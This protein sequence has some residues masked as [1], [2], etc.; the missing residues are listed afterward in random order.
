MVKVL[1]MPR[2]IQV[3]PG[4]LQSI[5]KVTD[6]HLTKQKYI[7]CSSQYKHN[8]LFPLLFYIYII[9]DNSSRLICI[10][11]TTALLKIYV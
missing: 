10:T 1:L 11:G 8:K 9:W 5:H 2:K 6:I 3:Y 4:K 7:L